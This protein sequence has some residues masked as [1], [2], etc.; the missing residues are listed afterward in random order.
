MI[1]NAALKYVS[2]ALQCFNV[3]KFLIVAELIKD[4]RKIIFP[5]NLSFISLQH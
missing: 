2:N 5:K 3:G 1:F 4:I